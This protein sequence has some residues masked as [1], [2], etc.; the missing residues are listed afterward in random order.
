MTPPETLALGRPPGAAADSPGWTVRVVPNKYPAFAGQEVIVHG[1]AH[2]TRFAELGAEVLDAVAAAWRAARAGG[3]PTTVRH[4]CWC[5]STR[6]RAQV[7]HSTT[8]TPSWCRSTRCRRCCELELAA[9]A[10]S[11]PLCDD[12]DRTNADHVVESR[13]GD[14]RSSAR[15]GAGSR[16][17]P[18]SFR[19]TTRRGRDG[20]QVMTHAIRRAVARLQTGARGRPRVERDRARFAAG[21]ARLPLAHRAAAPADGAGVGGVRSRRVGEHRRSAA[22]AASSRAA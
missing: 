13:D 14:S 2:V 10:D 7:R 16:S 18:G 1:P 17:K 15:A 20:P 21:R 11:C 8:H 6:A 9:M 19:S 5:V 22:A 4:G 3:Q 12:A